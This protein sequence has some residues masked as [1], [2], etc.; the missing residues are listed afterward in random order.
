MPRHKQFENDQK[1]NTFLMKYQ[2]CFYVPTY[3]FMGHKPLSETSKSDS[4]RV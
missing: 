3:L 4:D 2:S 1:N